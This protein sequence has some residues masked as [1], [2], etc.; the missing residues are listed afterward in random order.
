RLLVLADFSPR[1]AAAFP[2]LDS[3]RALRAEVGDAPFILMSRYER[4]EL[5]RHVSGLSHDAFLVKPVPIAR[6]QELLS[7]YLPG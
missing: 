7:Q 3:Y 4:E 1:P 2:E 6:Y 5:A